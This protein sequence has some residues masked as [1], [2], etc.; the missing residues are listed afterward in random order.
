MRSLIRASTLA[1][2]V[3]AASAVAFDPPQVVEVPRPAPAKWQEFRTE[4]GRAVRLSLKDG[5]PAVWVLAEEGGA[6][7]LTPQDTPAPFVD[8]VGP[9]GRHCLVAYVQG[10][11]PARIV[12][13]VGDDSP[14]RPDPDPPDPPSPKSEAVWVVIVEESSARR[15]EHAAV[16]NDKAFWDGVS[17]RGHKWRVYDRDSEDARKYGYAKRADGVGL[18]AV[19][20]YDVRSGAHL[21]TFRLP[22]TTAELDGEIKAVTK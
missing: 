4:P 17:A 9:K 15:P 22:K 10:Q 19:I 12:V 11:Q 6:S 20:L 16:I 7:S 21:K 14:P 1:L 2:F 13:V 3:V 8:F 5:A 18:P